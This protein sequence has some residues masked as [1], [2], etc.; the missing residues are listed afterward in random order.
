[1]HGARSVQNWSGTSPSDR[2]TI[3]GVR[4]P[5]M[6]QPLRDRFDSVGLGV[7]I[8]A[9]AYAIF[10]VSLLRHHGG[11]ISIFV[12]AAGPGV[13]RARVPPG[14]TVQR[15][16]GGYDGAA[17]YRLA[18][19][20]FTRT[21]TAFGITLDNPPYRQQR[22]GYP[23]V[24]HCLALGRSSWVPAL[25]VAVNFCALLAL[26]VLGAVAARQAGLHALWGLV[27]PFYPGFLL[28]LSRDLSEIVAC[29]LALAA[30]LALQSRRAVAAGVL[31]SLTLLTRETFLV[32]ALA[33]A[34]VFCVE[35]VRRLPS[36]P[37][38]VAFA[39]PLAIYAAWQW[40]LASVWGISPLEAGAPQFTLPFVEYARFVHASSS[41][42]G[43]ARLHFT[44]A[45]FLAVVMLVVVA[46]WRSSRS[47]TEWRVAWVG[48]FALAATLP[49]AVWFEDAGFLRVL[50]DLYLLSALL[51]ISANRAARATLAVATFLL[52]YYLAGHLVKYG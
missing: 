4:L 25:L 28:S 39:L 3:H 7:L 16:I 52:W 5:T 13:D 45:F 24:V 34:A 27:F 33:I 9:V 15:D 47:P 8:V 42:R 22:I 17:F 38:V 1:M 46:A 2:G 12:L 32:V 48:Y 23:F 31:L 10:L 41:L 14:L 35:A 44:E 20:P 40:R 29:G 51:V 36:R 19:D 11:D 43:A 21:A 30:L 26:G 6:P 37:P 18:L 50:A 49:H